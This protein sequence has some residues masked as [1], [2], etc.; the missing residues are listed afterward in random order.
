MLLLL[1]VPYGAAPDVTAPV[2]TS[3][4]GVETGQTTASGT[5]T[6]DEA[7]GTL[8][9]ICDQSGTAPSV[10]QI[11]A[12]LDNS[13]ASADAAGSQTVTGTGLQA[14]SVTGLAVYTTYYMHYQHQDAAA[15]DST[16]VTSASFTTDASATWTPTTDN[17]QT[18]TPTT[19]NTLTWTES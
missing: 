7:N 15:N 1:D 17:T 18:W 11:Q 2:L 12:G 8:Y 4:T 14:V 16:V 3:P 9:W 6:T 5:V 13:G 10:G 19:D